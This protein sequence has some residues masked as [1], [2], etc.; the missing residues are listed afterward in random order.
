MTDQLISLKTAKLA[1]E[2]GFNQN[3]YKT[4]NAYGPEFTDGSNIKLRSSS[5]FNPDTNT[6]VAPTQSLLQKWLR[7]TYFIHIVIQVFHDTSGLGKK[8]TFSADIFYENGDVDRSG[9]TEDTYE[10]ALE[11]GLQEALKLVTIKLICNNCGKEFEDNQYS[12]ICPS[13]YI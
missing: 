7:E 8:W 4:A 2:K 10:E 6:A 11:Q 3:P 12:P 5:L 1:R 13:C 9:L